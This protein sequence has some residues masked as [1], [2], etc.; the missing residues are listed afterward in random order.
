MPE[1][2]SFAAPANLRTEGLEKVWLLSLYPT[3]DEVVGHT[4][5]RQE[6]TCSRNESICQTAIDKPRFGHSLFYSWPLNRFLFLSS[7]LI[8]TKCFLSWDVWESQSERKCINLESCGLEERKGAKP[9]LRSQV[10][11]TEARGTGFCTQSTHENNW[12]CLPVLGRQKQVDPWSSLASQTSPIGKSNQWKTPAKNKVDCSWGMCP[13]VNLGPLHH[14]GHHTH[15]GG[16]REWEKE[17]ER[18]CW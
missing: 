4:K 17:K 5:G 12:V 15:R 9:L 13:K 16:G 18:E 14:H 3:R 1:W 7:I 10:L 2:G 6:L 11:A 8:H